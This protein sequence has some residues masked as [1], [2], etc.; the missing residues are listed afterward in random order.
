MTPALLTER[1]TEHKK[2]HPRHWRETV[3]NNNGYGFFGGS[4]PYRAHAFAAP[5]RGTSP[6]F[7]NY[8]DPTPA[9]FTV[10]IFDLAL[11]E[12]IIE[13][14]IFLSQRQNSPFRSPRT[15]YKQDQL[16]LLLL[17]FNYSYVSEAEQT[18]SSYGKSVD[19]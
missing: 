18:I 5:T 1:R 19:L 2:S 8:L 3:R 17:V 7:A 15:N 12:E 11:S 16:F 10:N 9:P 6:T 4:L 14:I 13:L